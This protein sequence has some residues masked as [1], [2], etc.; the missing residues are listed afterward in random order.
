MTDV[1]YKNT[2]SDDVKHLIKWKNEFPRSHIIIV[3]LD[4]NC[5]HISLDDNAVTY[6][7]IAKSL[8]YDK[9]NNNIVRALENINTNDIYSVLTHIESYT[10]NIVPELKKNHQRDLL[11]QNM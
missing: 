7:F 5:V 1:N 4:D 6:W 8:T 3:N 2:L 10:S 11:P 9:D